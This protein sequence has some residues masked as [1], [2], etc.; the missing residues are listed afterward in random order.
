MKA[1]IIS[2]RVCANI[3]DFVHGGGT[4]INRLL[5]ELND[6]THMMINFHENELCIFR[7]SDLSRQKYQV[8]GEVEV[9]SEL[10]EAAIAI[11]MDKEALDRK[12]DAIKEEVWSLLPAVE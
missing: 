5:V 8:V 1:T 10:M 11:L 7:V 4:L 3:N 2:Q 9:S 6:G 12:K